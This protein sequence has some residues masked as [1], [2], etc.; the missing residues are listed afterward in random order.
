VKR[1]YT[2]VPEVLHAAAALSVT[3]HLVK[4]EREGR[5]LRDDMDGDPQHS[6]WRSA[7][8]PA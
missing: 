8:A 3:S 6:R 4:L 2:D 7:E 5:T 1:V